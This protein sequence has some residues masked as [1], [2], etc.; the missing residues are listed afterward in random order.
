MLSQGYWPAEFLTISSILTK[1]P[2]QYAKSFLYTETDDNDL[3]YFITYQLRI[4]IRAIN[5][6]EG[7]LQRKT[8]EVR[9]TE[10]L[11]KQLATLNH[12]Q[13]ALLNHALR[14]PDHPYTVKSHSTSHRIA[15]QT[16]RTDLDGPGG[17]RA[18]RKGESRKGLRVL[19][20][21]GSVEPS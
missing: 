12:R 10:K 8:A 3:T 13:T 2:V 7:Y 19:P 5:A 14:H 15:I 6:L 4:I 1:A 18:A 11:I 9:R 16:A 17:A 21:G 20:G